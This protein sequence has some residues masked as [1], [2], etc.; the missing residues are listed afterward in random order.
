MLQINNRLGDEFTNVE[1]FYSKGDDVRIDEAQ[2]ETIYGKVIR[3]LKKKQITER[4]A[5]SSSSLYEDDFVKEFSLQHTQYPYRIRY[6]YEIEYSQF[7]HVANWNPVI[8]LDVPTRAASLW[9]EV[10]KGYEIKI[11]QNKV[12]EPDILSNGNTS[13]YKWNS[14]Y[15][16][17]V[18]YEA[19]ATPVLENIPRV[20]V[21]P[22][23]FHLGVPGS[24]ES[25]ESFG[26]WH[27][28]LIQGLNTLSE[29]DRQM[30]QD[31][32]TSTSDTMQII[33]QL[34]HYLQ[35]NTRYI[36]V[37][38]DIG[39][40]KPYPAEYVSTNGYGDCKALSNY[41]KALLECAGIKSY[42]TKVYA[43]TKPLQVNPEFPSQQFN[44]II[45][46]VPVNNDSVWLECTSDVVPFGYLGTFTQNRSVLPV[47][48]EGS[49]LIQTPMLSFEQVHSVCKYNFDMR[50][51]NT[52][53]LSMHYVLRG[54]DFE[55]LEN[56][57]VNYNNKDKDKILREILP[58]TSFKLNDWKLQRTNHDKAQVDLKAQIQL[59][60][61]VRE[62]GNSIVF[63]V[64]PSR[65]P[66][67]EKPDKRT[68][69]VW[70]NY[71]IFQTDSITFRAPSDYS[72]EA[73]PVDV[74]INNKYGTYKIEYIHK[75][76]EILVIRKFKLNPAKYSLEEYPE[77]YHFLDRV[78]QSEKQKSIM[79]T[80]NDN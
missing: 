78:Y 65:I 24:F 64:I 44:H 70:I 21:V 36:N 54:K 26:N 1:I 76:T 71:P 73:K 57:R 11:S 20:Q 32:V 15:T 12:A 51:L 13:I 58:L 49:K 77:F 16:S 17:Q 2:I 31:L 72:L 18:K 29:K 35:D 50:L 39:G 34:Y 27:Y 43:G 63:D 10:P 68:L 5:I 61:Y 60:R 69:P 37:K 48:K 8:D 67:F 74:H 3:K 6:S 62:Y 4:S 46:M 41:L 30:V 14:A 55:N 45:L 79:L 56:F 33:K 42:Y 52:P 47:D 38:I 9:I 7:M 75:D 53:T 66:V 22:K 23:K 28:R 25:W 19:Y 40:L 59:T 80:R